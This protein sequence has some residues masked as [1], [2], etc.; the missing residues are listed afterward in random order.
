MTDRSFV[1]TNVL[2]YAVGENEPRKRAIVLE[3][4]AALGDRFVISTQVLG[5]FFVTVT[6]K[7]AVPVSIAAAA[8][9]VSELSQHDTVPIDASLVRAAIATARQ[10]QLSYCDALIIEAAVA[11]GCPTLLSEDLHGGAMIRGVEVVNPFA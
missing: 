9:R 11:G 2:V 6:R 1:D 5:E 10:S 7:I 4:L 3:W 8:E